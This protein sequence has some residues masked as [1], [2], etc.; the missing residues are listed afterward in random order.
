[1]NKPIICSLLFLLMNCSSSPK[2]TESNAESN[3]AQPNAKS[4]KEMLISD[5]VQT[6]GNVKTDMSFKMIS[7][8]KGRD[9][10]ARDSLGIIHQPL[11]SQYENG[12][13]IDSLVALLKRTYEKNNG[14]GKGAAKYKSI[15]PYYTNQNRLLAKGYNCKYTIKNPAL[16]HAS[17]EITRTFYFSLDETKIL[18]AN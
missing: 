5:Y 1:M 3:T 18:A 15:A 10:L 12:H 17:Q 2:I 9:I 13:N 14:Q 8:E 11:A 6:D 4:E 16:N 7:I